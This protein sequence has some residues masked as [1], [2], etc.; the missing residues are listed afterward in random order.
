MFPPRRT[1]AQSQWVF[2]VFFSLPWGEVGGVQRPSER[3][4]T[5]SAVP[6][7]GLRHG[8]RG[9]PAVA[10]A[11]QTP[12][13]RHAVQRVNFLSQRTPEGDRGVRPRRGGGPDWKLSQWWRP[14]PP[15][16]K[17]LSVEG[18]WV[19]SPSGKGSLRA[20][21]SAQRSR[22]RVRGDP[23]RM[24]DVRAS[25]PPLDVSQVVW[26]RQR[27]RLSR[28][29]L[30][31]HVWVFFFFWGKKEKRPAFSYWGSGCCVCVSKDA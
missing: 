14:R 8:A 7:T 11:E 20:Y 31:P 29:E 10:G 19:P 26:P 28:S 18:L 24:D 6:P 5:A 17:G 16:S 15:A 3:R 4:L 30:Y 12:A 27:A 9:L 22:K 1:R 21:S 13:H 23:L 2:C 25:P